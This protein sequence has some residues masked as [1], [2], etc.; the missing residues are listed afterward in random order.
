MI[1][2]KPIRTLG[3]L[4]RGIIGIKLSPSDY[5]VSA[6]VIPKA[7]KYLFSINSEGNGKNT[8]ID[9]FNITGTNTKG[10][11]IQ[12]SDALC[13]FIPV[14]DNSDILINSSN[15]QI[16]IKHDD[17]P[18]LSRGTQGVRLMRLTATNDII[19]VSTI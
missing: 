3:R 19:G 15:A 16:R 5:V 13:D 9:E 2:S 17:I 11:K 1:E 12:K 8:S 18:I 4:T 14:I 6:R 7:T 10:V